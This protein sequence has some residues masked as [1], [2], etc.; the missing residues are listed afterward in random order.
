MATITLI[1]SRYWRSATA[2]VT[3][4]DPDNMYTDIS[5]STYATLTSTRKATTAYYAFINGFDMSS[6]PAGATVESFVVRIRGYRNSRISTNAA[7]NP[8]LTNTVSGTVFADTTADSTFGTS[9]TTI[10]VPTGSL[11]WADIVSDGANF[12]IRVSVTRSSSNYQ[13]Y[14]YIYGA[15]I[16]VTYTEGPAPSGLDNVYVKQNGLWVQAN[17][18]L[19]KQNGAWNEASEVK[20]KDNGTWK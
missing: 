9:D 17:K 10:V 14:L 20:A 4:T 15:E 13:G 11:T 5:S 8:C 18:M 16:D 12:S 2:Y 7:Y 1:P 3:V 19:V 6:I